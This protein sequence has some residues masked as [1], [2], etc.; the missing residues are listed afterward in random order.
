MSSTASKALLILSV[1]L[2]L[3]PPMFCRYR[4]WQIVFKVLSWV[5]IGFTAITGPLS[6]YIKDCVFKKVPTS[7]RVVYDLSFSFLYVTNIYICLNTILRQRKLTKL[8]E[9]C[10]DVITESRRFVVHFACIM[11][12]N[13]VNTVFIVLTQM[14][15]TEDKY[16]YL[17]L[18]MVEGF[19]VFR[20]STALFVIFLLVNKVKEDLKE[21]NTEIETWCRRSKERVC[22]WNGWREH[23]KLCDTVEQINDLFGTVLMWTIF[24]FITNFLRHGVFITT[25]KVVTGSSVVRCLWIC[26]YGVSLPSELKQLNLKQIYFSFRHVISHTW[27]RKYL[28][29]PNVLRQYATK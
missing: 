20:V 13:T 1:L 27:G 10:L 17:S 28:K 14:K 26:S 21:F 29:K 22:R 24:Y 2:I 25:N 5:L 9:S 19:L 12:L 15:R 18:F 16:Y 23:S 8:L 4:K 3:F 6:V 11:F 7:S